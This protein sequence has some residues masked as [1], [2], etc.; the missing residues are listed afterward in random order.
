MQSKDGNLLT[1]PEEIK[2]RWRE[3]IE[4]LYAKD[5]KPDHIPLEPE[6]EVDMDRLGP[7]ILKEEIIKAIDHLTD[8]KLEGADGIPAEMWKTIGTVEVDTFVELCSNIY[9][10]IYIYIYCYKEK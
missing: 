6:E 7:E 5:E 9:I 3:Y 1:G 10:Y 8:G 2:E 4:E